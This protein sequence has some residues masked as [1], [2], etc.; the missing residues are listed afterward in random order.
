[1]KKILGLTASVFALSAVAMADFGEAVDGATRHEGLIE[2]YV[3]SGTGQVLVA[4]DA[5]NED[6]VLGRYIHAGYLT[7]GLGSNPV[8]LDRSVPGGSQILSFRKMGDKVAVMV[9][10]TDF[11]ATA[12]NKAEQKAVETSF[13]Q[14]IIW[15]TSILEVEEGTGRILIDLSGFLKRDPVGVAARLKQT[16]Q[17]NFRLAADKSFV[18]TD[19]AFVF[20]EN[21]EFD[22]YVTFESTEPGKEVRATTPVPGSV[23]L[24]AHNSFLR[25]PDDGYEVRLSDERAAII[26]N[27]YV[28]MSSALEGDTVVKLARRFRLQK[29]ENGKV[30][31]PIIFYVD[32]GAPEPIRSALVEGGNWWAEAFE[33]A[34][35]PGGYRVEV[36]PEGV[37]PL[38]ARY[39]VVNWV[40]RATRG[41]SYG[42]ALHDPRTGEVLRGVVLLG[43]LRVRQDIKIFE[44]LAGADKTGTGAADDP[45]QLALHRIR[46]LSA[47][48]IGHA[49]GFAHNMAGSSYGD[50][51][52]VMDYP[53][54]DVRPDGNGG[55]DFSNTYGTGMGAWD[56]W[57]VKFLY[58]DYGDQDDRTAQ[59]AMIKAAD[60]AGL[61]FVSDPDS[62]PL[63]SG[64]IYGSLW[65]NG[66]DAVDTLTELMEV[67]RIALDTFGD[68]NLRPGENAKALQTKFVPLYLY[69]RYQLQAAAKYVGGYDFAYRHQGDGRAK[70]VAAS[71][72]KQQQAL[73]ALL[74]TISPGA[75]RISDDVFA[76]LS[77]LGLSSGDPQF[78]RESFSQNTRPGFDRLGAARVAADLTLSA[79]LH[80]ARVARLV[81][82]GA[83]VP[84][85]TGLSGVLDTMTDAI[86]DMP[87]GESV[88]DQNL[89]REVQMRYAM[90]LIGLMQD[91]ATQI[92][93]RAEAKTALKAVAQAASK[94]RSGPTATQALVLAEM[95]EDA[96]DRAKTP[97]VK[98][99]SDPTIPPGSP[100]GMPAM[101]AGAAE[102]CWHCD[103]SLE[104]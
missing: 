57:T 16:G 66:T 26:E 51:E 61:R 10:N 85:H 48:E 4:L 65:D 59:A 96:F 7:A 98:L 41:W 11:R 27:T 62:R 90:H 34:G 1:M 21:L 38:D 73:E 86:M 68:E 84:G 31:N 97:A 53:A 79:L 8:G 25:L 18:K 64:N 63:G 87:R 30:I 5:P 40:H 56:M 44:A 71:W 39:N 91:E 20:P 70:P 23:T 69:H 99:P 58:G 28:D 2:T 37:H 9:E 89:R 22:S 3:Q 45:V 12:N 13:A 32:N 24:I 102:T 76:A 100:I 49:L 17:G 19:A 101:A 52:S 88:G 81:D 80:P 72:S 92:S 94:Q 78:G 42:A 54:P 15:S 29:D 55:L 60:E 104:D 74:A 46:Q 36:L 6:G 103:T 82:Q 67:R 35:F 75:L 50:R 95:I 43:S 14:S 33:A 83:T 77:P 47:H 93:V